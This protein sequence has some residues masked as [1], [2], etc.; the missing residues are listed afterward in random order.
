VPVYPGGTPIQPLP[1]GPEQHPG[2]GGGPEYPGFVPVYPGGSPEQPI[3]VPV[4]PSQLPSY[5]R[6]PVD[7][8]YG[9][10]VVP[11]FGSQLPEV[12][13]PGANPPDRPSQPAGRMVYSQRYG[14]V[15][16][17]YLPSANPP[18]RPT[19]P[20]PPQRPPDT[21]PPPDAGNKPIETPDP[22][23]F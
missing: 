7:P 21:K 5:P 16:D 20:E 4:F 12:P 8:G 18:D 15:Y 9:R 19:Q 17:P 23:N 6:R 1:I 22:K 10:P 3:Y 14:W 2:I 13:P 11:P